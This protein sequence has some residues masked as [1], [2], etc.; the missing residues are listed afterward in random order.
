MAKNVQFNGVVPEMYQEAQRPSSSFELD[1]LKSVGEPFGGFLT[2]AGDKWRFFEH[3]VYAN[4]PELRRKQRVQRKLRPGEDPTYTHSILAVRVRNGKESNEWFSLNFLAKTDA[5][6][7]P[8]NESWYKLGDA[9]K[10]LEKLCKM[11]EIDVLD[12]VNI[13]TAVF[14][15]G[16]PNRVPTLD[17]VT[18]E[19]L[20]AADGTALTHVET[21][22]QESHH[23]TPVSDAE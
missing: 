15:G 22:D 19:Q 13:K 6:R 1:E 12:N 10:R 2:E 21:R 11:T 9:G 14:Q 17:P 16:R 8:V 20:V 7:K 3:S 5:E 23:I 18:K 4:N